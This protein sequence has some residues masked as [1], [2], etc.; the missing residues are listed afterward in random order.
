MKND[1]GNFPLIRAIL[2]CAFAVTAF[3]YVPTIVAKMIS[4]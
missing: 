3:L 1:S 2:T 4:M